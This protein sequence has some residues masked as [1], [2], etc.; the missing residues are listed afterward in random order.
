[1]CPLSVRITAVACLCFTAL[2]S[3]LPRGDAAARRPAAYDSLE[4]GARYTLNA[5]K[6]DFH[7]FWDPCHGPDI[8]FATAYHTGRLWL[9]ARYLFVSGTAP[10]Y[11]DYQSTFI[12][13]GWSYPLCFARRLGVEPG[14]VLGIDSFF[15]EDEQNTGLENE[16]ET[17]GELFVRA[18]CGLR[19]G[20]RLNV[21]VS[22]HHV[23]TSRRIN[24]LYVSAGLSRFFST[25]GW[26]RRIME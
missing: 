22:S 11:P 3:P 4:V 13:A 15:F 17:A 12:Y 23:F 20:W 9:G 19:A 1:M 16:T 18:S 6:N 25:P 24:L 7:E 2:L 5:D 10:T 21:T 14:A 26:I 8:F